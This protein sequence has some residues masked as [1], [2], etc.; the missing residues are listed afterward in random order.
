MLIGILNAQPQDCLIRPFR[1]NGVNAAMDVMDTAAGC[2]WELSPAKV[3]L[4]RRHLPPP[5][6]G[7]QAARAPDNTT[8]QAPLS[9]ELIA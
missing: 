5:H 7:K 2:V 6:V 9:T 4:F 3:G 1:E 8:P